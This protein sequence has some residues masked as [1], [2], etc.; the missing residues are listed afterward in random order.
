M[1]I[2]TRRLTVD[3]PA[4]EKPVVIRLY[5][6]EF[7]DPIWDCRYEIDWPDGTRRGHMQGND[8]LQALLLVQMII[9]ADL[10]SSRYHVER[11]MWWIKPWVGYGFPLEKSARDVLIGHDALFYGQ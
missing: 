9:G 10:Y 4:G 7:F 5:A 11:K 1:I 8:S 3:T 6:P 2:G